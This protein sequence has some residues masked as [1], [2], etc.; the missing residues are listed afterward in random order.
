MK[1]KCGLQSGAAQFQSSMRERGSHEW[2]CDLSGLSKKTRP[3]RERHPGFAEF[4][5]QIEIG[6][7]IEVVSANHRR[8]P[9]L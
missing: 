4:A 2:L 8:S 9:Q 1:P 6:W 3:D 7:Q 5:Q